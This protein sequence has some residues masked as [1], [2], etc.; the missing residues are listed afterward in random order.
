M[1]MNLTNFW[2]PFFMGSLEGSSNLG[3]YD[4][5]YTIEIFSVFTFGLNN[6]L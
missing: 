3:V 2:K 1:G 4:S 6:G 5:L